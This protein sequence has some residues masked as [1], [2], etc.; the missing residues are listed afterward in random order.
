MDSKPVKF[1][2][3]GMVYSE[4]DNEVGPKIVC[5]EPAGF[6]PQESFEAISNFFFTSKD[7][8][9]KVITLNAFHHR[10]MGYSI[11]LVDD[12]YGRS[13]L[14]FNIC[15]VF[16]ANTDLSA[17][18]PIL[19]KLGNI[20]ESLELEAEF[21]YKADSREKLPSLMKRMFASLNQ[22]GECSVVAN[23]ANKINLKLF[24]KLEPPPLVKDYEV[25]VR[26]KDLDTLVKS[27]WDITIQ[28]VKRFFFFLLS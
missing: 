25:P 16:P 14:F 21:L 12:K 8:C 27:S 22:Q 17:Y 23:Q 15:F 1:P 6:L 9:H 3:E 2:L 18:Q 20:L 5:Q 13:T 19:S 26:I 4:F 11:R 24:P 28:R 10:F 7:L